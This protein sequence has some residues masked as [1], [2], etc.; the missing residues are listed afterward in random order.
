MVKSNGHSGNEPLWFMT[1]DIKKLLYSVRNHIKII[2]I[3]IILIIIPLT[4]MIA[5]KQ[6]DVRQRAAGEGVYLY[7]TKAG[8]T[9]PITNIN[10]KPGDTI[11]LALNLDI[12]TG[13]NVINYSV[14]TKFEGLS[15]ISIENL[16]DGANAQNK[17]KESGPPIKLENNSVLFF[18]MVPIDDILLGRSVNELV[19]D[20]GLIT[21]KANHEGSVRI[22]SAEIQIASLPSITSQPQVLSVAPVNLT[23]RIAGGGSASSPTPSID[24]TISNTP[25]PT[26]TT[27]DFGE[28]P[29]DPVGFVTKFYGIGLS[30]IGGLAL[31]F[32]IYGGYLVMTSSGNPEQLA[33]GK[34]RILYAVIGLLLA[35]FGY[36][37]VQILAGDI[38]KIPGFGS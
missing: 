1:I 10:L 33:R 35:I 16:G 11:R 30:F 5:Q 32:I 3:L 17:F 28:I 24:D 18:R 4:V 21:L 25:M 9:S 37:F 29:T 20:I 2:F 22:H 14:I 8:E 26:S 6:Q 19:N 12:P 27:T 38:L 7:F 36:I 31:L 15:I 34:S 13:S 23:F